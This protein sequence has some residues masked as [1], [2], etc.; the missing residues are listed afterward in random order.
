MY[1]Y[2]NSHVKISKFI[3]ISDSENKPPDGLNLCPLS[4]PHLQVI[5]E[6]SLTLA[7]PPPPVTLPTTWPGLAGFQRSCRRG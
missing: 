3:H 7:P 1:R 2:I 4:G 6:V 5:S